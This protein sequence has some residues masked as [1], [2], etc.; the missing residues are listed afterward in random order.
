MGG[1]FSNEQIEKFV[2]DLIVEKA[3]N[4]DEQNRTIE[5]DRLVAI[6]SDKI[7]DA[8]AD[9]IPDEKAEAL[10]KLMDEKGDNATE[11]EVT[12]ILYASQ[13]DINDAVKK[14]MDEFRESYLKGEI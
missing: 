5:K 7:E 14:T 8:I 11:E 6:L 9:C 12:A 2:Q 3:D 10:N 1:N 13:L 4:L